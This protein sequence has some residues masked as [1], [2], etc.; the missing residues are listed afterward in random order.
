MNIVLTWMVPFIALYLKCWNDESQIRL[1]Y[2]LIPFPV[3][4]LE[5][6]RIVIKIWGCYFHRVKS[7]EKTFFSLPF[8]VDS[9]D[10]TLYGNMSLILVHRNLIN[11]DLHFILRFGLVW[12]KKNLEGILSLKCVSIKFAVLNLGQIHFIDQKYLKPD[13]KTGLNITSGFVCVCCEFTKFY[14]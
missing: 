8:V 13:F 3:F 9:K 2:P 1:R 5:R 12:L 14:F 11:F 4:F 10:V 6:R 7:L